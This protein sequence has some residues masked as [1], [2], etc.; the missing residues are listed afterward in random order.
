M[1]GANRSGYVAATAHQRLISEGCS[2]DKV[3]R[4]CFFAF[5]MRWA[6]MTE[7]PTVWNRV[8]PQLLHLLPD[9]KGF[10]LVRSQR[11]VNPEGFPAYW[12]NCL[13]DDHA[14]QKDAFLVP[15]VDNLS[16]APRPNLSQIAAAYLD[17]WGLATQPEV[18]LHHALATLYSPLYLDENAD[19]LRQGW[20]R[21]PLP[22]TIEYLHASA[23][24]GSRLAVLL[25]PD[26][27]V[28]GVD[29]GM[30]RPELVPIGEPRTSPGLER[31][32]N[33]TG[34]GNRTESG[35]TMP[36]RGV[37]HMRS[38]AATEATTEGYAALLGARMVDVGIG[39]G[40]FWHGVPEAVWECRIG[41]YQ[42]LKKWLSYRDRS[43]IRRPLLQAEISHFQQTA[44]RIAAILLLGP[45]LDASYQA[46]ILD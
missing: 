20:P 26:V 27:S 46:C 19:G 34:W 8:R 9:A 4:Y 40:S 16:G 35:V 28:P 13:A 12:T 31:N 32:W 30:P 22:R 25:N 39:P 23:L 18:L 33:L 29:V 44:R 17:Q 6:Y 45:A 38:Y 24:L 7:E 3:K 43:I 15:V 41:G 10:L 1:L 36:L 37:A 5:D 11:I 21:I 2:I 14:L 42:V